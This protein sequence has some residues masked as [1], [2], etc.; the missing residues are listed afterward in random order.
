MVKATSRGL[1]KKSS[2]LT[3]GF[4]FLF[5]TIGRNKKRKSTL[6]TIE[7][8]FNLEVPIS[9]SKEFELKAYIPI[10]RYD[11]LEHSLNQKVYKNLSYEYFIRNDIFKVLELQYSVK[12]K[13]NNKK[14]VGLLDVLF[15]E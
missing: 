4:G 1:G 6:R 7:Y 3:R 5:K 9:N 2:L 12:T 13:M 14:L 8:Y 11:Y 10:V 15:E